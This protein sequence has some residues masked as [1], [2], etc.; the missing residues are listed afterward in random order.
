MA[1]AQQIDATTINVQFSG[2]EPKEFFGNG[3]SSKF[4]SLSRVTPQNSSV[5]FAFISSV[6]AHAFDMLR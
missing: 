2:Y 6:E 4:G 5:D 3:Y 1:L